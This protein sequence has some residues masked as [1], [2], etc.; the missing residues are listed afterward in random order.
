MDAPVAPPCNASSR[1]LRLSLES[2]MAVPWHLRQ[3]F[4]KI[5][6]MSLANDTGV[7]ICVC[8]GEAAVLKVMAAR[9]MNVAKAM[10]LLKGSSVFFGVAPLTCY[11]RCLSAG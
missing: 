5:G 7:P 9:Q 3:L 4:S 8:A 1:V 6:R 10:R 2:C 11:N